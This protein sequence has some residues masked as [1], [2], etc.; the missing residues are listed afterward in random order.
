[1]VCDNVN[2]SNKK[3]SICDLCKHSDTCK[4]LDPPVINK[5]L[6]AENEQKAEKDAVNLLEERMDALK[7]TQNERDQFL[8][9]HFKELG[10]ILMFGPQNMENDVRIL[11]LALASMISHLMFASYRAY[12]LG[13][14]TRERLLEII[15]TTAL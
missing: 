9:E 4:D 1:M 6:H 8:L 2:N 10:S 12:K 13:E 15:D 7:T 14:I 11:K 5:D 3:L